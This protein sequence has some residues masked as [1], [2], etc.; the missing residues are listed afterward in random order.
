MENVLGDLLRESLYDTQYNIN[1]F[2]LKNDLWSNATEKF[3]V[4]I[5]KH[6][7]KPISLALKNA[8]LY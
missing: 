5:N 2:S 7:S 3:S 6:F 1:E 4:N 8:Y